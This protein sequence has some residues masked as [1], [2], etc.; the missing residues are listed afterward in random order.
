[1]L[2]ADGG[3]LHIRP[4]LPTDG[5]RLREL[6]SRLS[7]R[8]I[9]LRYFGPRPTLSD[10][11]LVRLAQLD[12][13]D[14]VALVAEVRG[15]LVA[16][17]RYERLVG[18]PPSP[19]GSPFA[20]V[21]RDRPDPR[22]AEVAF[23]VEDA[24]QRRGIGSVLLEHLAAAARERGITTFDAYVLA[25]NQPMVRVFRDAGYRADREYDS[26]TIHMSIA[27][28]PTTRSVAV[29]YEREQRAEARSVERLLAPRSVAVIGASGDPA[30]L[31]HLVFRN[32]LG[33]GPGGPIYPISPVAHHIAGVR[34]Y[35]TVLDVPDDLDLV[36]VAV[37]AHQVPS[38]DLATLVEECATKHARGLVVVS[39]GFGGQGVPGQQGVPGP[40]GAPGRQL[41]RDLVAAARAHGMRVVGPHC[42]GVLNTDPRVRINA[43][44]AP[45]APGQISRGR[46]GCFC[47]SAVFGVAMLEEAAARG[48]GL[49]TFV[50]AGDRADVSGNDLLQYWESDPETEVAVLY[51]ESFGN[52][53]KFTRL[54]RRLGQSTPIVAVRSGRQESRP[55]GL[56]HTVGAVPDERTAALFESTGVIRVDTVAHMFDVAQLLAYQPLPA[57]R[58]VGVV[59]NS[60]PLGAL[61]ADSCAA[62]ELAL[63]SGHPVEL[64]AGAGAVDFATALDRATAS[65]DVDALVV[66]VAPPLVGTGEEIARVLADPARRW[67]RP[68]VSTFLAVRGVPELLRRIGPDGT[69]LRGSIP[70]YSSPELAVLALA[71]AIRYAEWRAEPTGLVPELPELDEVAAHAVV[72]AALAEQPD[73]ADLTDAG[74]V[75]LLAAYG[76]ACWPTR[77]AATADAAAAAA[78][79]VGYPVALKSTVPALRFRGDL[80]GTRLDLADEAELRAAHGALE[81]LG[82]GPHDMVV[83]PMAPTGVAVEASVVDDPS[84]GAVVSFGL[85]G[86]AAE[87]LD[88]RGYAAVPLSDEHAR[89][90]VRAPRAAPMLFGYQGVAPVD[91]VALED[92]L[93]RLARLADDVPELLLLRLSPILVSTRGLAVL[94]ARARVGPATARAPAGPRRLRSGLDVVAQ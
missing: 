49:T 40:H 67:D 9:Y 31:G 51:L 84:F 30:T 60:A 37:P 81:R 86:P 6:H 77:R 74:T 71:R 83:Q 66:V 42:L 32:L 2:A 10:Q 53:R 47:Q 58:R 63:A 38:L 64:P 70:S 29:G 28:E 76:I 27:I 92:T 4:I 61:V 25:E 8:T 43:T 93:L 62:Q 5:E 82:G 19:A 21:D 65:S 11:D 90:L 3:V 52:P 87:L 16:V 59:T 18:P 91:V 68:V 80:G 94:G 33:Y 55:P 54:A 24:H 72:R 36:V 56:D 26:G 17:G 46:V 50:S 12:H 79:T 7:D 13:V 39:G 57:G 41:G 88:D 23:V 85:A 34:A 14:R 20:A 69:T 35:P 78:A 45:L 44:S 73:G 22:T 89:R 48:L 75:A 15:R 1:M